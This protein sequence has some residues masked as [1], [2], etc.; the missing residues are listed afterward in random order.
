MSRRPTLYVEQ[1]IFTQLADAKF[2]STNMDH[3]W[4][5]MRTGAGMAPPVTARMTMRPLLERMSVSGP[6]DAGTPLPLPS[7]R[8]DSISVLAVLASAAAS[9]T[10]SSN[11]MGGAKK[12][13]RFS[14]SAAANRMD[15]AL[16]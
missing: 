14:R 4:S 15:S 10:P 11:S 5:A 16:K 13:G 7:P 8:A 6:G 3:I 2:C 9:A 1:G 12:T